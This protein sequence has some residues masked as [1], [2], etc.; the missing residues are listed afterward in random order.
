MVS[1]SAERFQYLQ[2]DKWLQI[3]YNH[4]CPRETNTEK[5]VGKMFFFNCDSICNFDCSSIWQILSQLCGF[6][7]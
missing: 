7:C 1:V 2:L 3:S 5:E 6:G 4:T